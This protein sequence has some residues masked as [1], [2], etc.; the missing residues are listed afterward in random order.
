MAKAVP[1][2]Q[3]RK[4]DF[5][6][7]QLEIFCRV[8]ELGSVSKAAEVVNLTQ[9]SVSERM[10][11]LEGSIGAKLFDRIGRRN[12]LTNTG[13]LLY[14]LALKHLAL[15]EETLQALE[16]FQ[17]IRRGEVTIGG[18]TIPGEYILPGVIQRFHKDH[19]R[20][21][22]RLRI[23]DT[24]EIARD[25]ANGLLSFGVVGAVIENEFLKYETLW[26][27]ELVLIASASHHLAKS[28]SVA[29][30]DL[31]TE[32]FILRESGSGTRQLLERHISA[33]TTGKRIELNAVA[34]LGSSAAI[35]AGVLAG[36]GVSV[37]SARAVK[38]EVESGKLV[39]LPVAGLE[40]K[41]SFYLV[42][43]SRRTL[44]PLSNAF[45]EFLKSDK[46]VQ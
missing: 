18:S 5:D 22:L 15:K 27:D 33:A 11:S 29:L 39:I 2:A 16:G 13:K 43:D 7:R 25:V 23:Q 34:E 31:V 32:P 41:R 21:L 30:S 20:I 8:V 38:S 9:S 1:N 46:A 42:R 37:I 17:G 10:G 26:Q 6:L 40:Q 14:E 36:L 3:I 19:P 12:V 28:R 44:S 45:C 24:A 4:A 35:K